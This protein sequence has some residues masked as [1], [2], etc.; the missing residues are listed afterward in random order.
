MAA[1]VIENPVFSEFTT[2]FM[3]SLLSPISYKIDNESDF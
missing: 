3:K 2:S 1:S